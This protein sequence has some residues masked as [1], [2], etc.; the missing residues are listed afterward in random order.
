MEAP[1]LD[2]FAEFIRDWAR[3]PRETRISAETRFEDDLGI[4]GDDGCE[5]LQATEKR[6]KVSLSSE[7]HGFRET[8]NLGPNEFLFHSEGFGPSLPDLLT[9]FGRPEPVV[10]AFT[11]GELDDAVRRALASRRA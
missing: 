7:E 10:V 9:L 1:S 5:L 4:T 3:I 11:V 2:E 8:F 6:F